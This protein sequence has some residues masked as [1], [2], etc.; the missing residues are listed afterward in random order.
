MSNYRLPRVRG[1]IVRDLDGGVLYDNYGV[2]SQFDYADYFFPNSPDD[3]FQQ[4]VI[5]TIQ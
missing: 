5:T 4:S 1:F 3:N 2:L